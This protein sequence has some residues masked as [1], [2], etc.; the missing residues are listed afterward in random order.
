MKIRSLLKAFNVYF[1]AL[2][3]FLVTVGVIINPNF[4]ETISIEGIAMLFAS[5]AVISGLGI[6]LIYV[7]DHF[8][9]VPDDSKKCSYGE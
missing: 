1:L 5:T 3:V 6:L 7:C 8:E 9:S 2:F 4:W